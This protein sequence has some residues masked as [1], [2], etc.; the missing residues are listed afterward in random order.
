MPATIEKPF[1]R[2][3]KLERLAKQKS[4]ASEEQKRGNVRKTASFDFGNSLLLYDGTPLPDGEWDIL[5]A[6]LETT[7]ELNVTGA[8][9][10]ELVCNDPEF[11][12]LNDSWFEKWMLEP[13]PASSEKT[14]SKT[15]EV[16][17]DVESILGEE[18][19]EA[20][21][22][23]P[24]KH[25][26]LRLDGTWFRLAGFKVNEDKLTLLWEDLLA[27]ILRA[28]VGSVFTKTRS[29]SMTRAKFAHEL[30][31]AAVSNPKN[32][33][34]G[35]C[36]FWCPEEGIKQQVE[37]EAEEETPGKGGEGEAASEEAGSQE[38][39][40]TTTDGITVKGVAATTSQLKVINEGLSA[41]GKLSAPFKAKVALVEALI[42]ENG[43]SN[44]DP[45]NEADMGCL[46]V[47]ASTARGLGIN[48][49][50]IVAVCEHFLA[51][52]FAG[53][54]GAI[55]IA[56]AEPNL[57]AGEIAQKVQGSGAGAASKGEA[58]YGKWKAEAEKAVNTFQGAKGGTTSSSANTAPFQFTR[59]KNQTSW[60]CIQALAQEVGWYAFVRGNTLFWVSGEYLY[61][62]P[63][64]MLVERGKGGVDWV[65]PVVELGARD[66]VAE[67]EVI[68][69]AGT[70]TALPGTCVRVA[71]IGPLN[72]KWLVNSITQDVRDPSEAIVVK[73]QK[74]LPAKK[75]KPG[76]KAS[77]TKGGLKTAEGAFDAA[78]KLS[79]MDLD[80]KLGGGH[81]PGA[82]AHISKESP[83]P[84]DCS[85]STSWIL[86]EAGMFPS[87]TAED[88]SELENWGDPGEGKEMTVW[89]NS[90][91][92]FIEFKIPGH[93]PA[94]A[95]TAYPNSNGPR[96]ITNPVFNT[97][98]K[99]EGFTPRHWPGT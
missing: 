13:Q 81:G 8:S 90:A 21:W 2:D 7:L 23:L 98:P 46:S 6:V 5:A 15:A 50:D 80:Y 39:A 17:E 93:E 40:L 4:L 26:D 9:T 66:S 60:D 74:P 52:G 58:T 85:S 43:C 95:N 1:A 18:D 45:G 22:V 19:Q 30:F 54:G 12:L 61:D 92:V 38:N 16:K 87:T 71:R 96:L 3:P 88:S 97:N 72:G 31:Q 75:E 82:L 35:D 24:E 37:A 79:E 59:G 53:A 14:T 76:S 86:H 29:G 57:S 10:F 77:T 55:A 49:Y 20:R 25:I 51:A 94:Q 89:A 32:K 41:C 69:R 84:L 33:V 36:A 28:E 63:T 64:Q 48:V 83:E 42:T 27:A 62:Q 11:S 91:H 73:L 68:A 47:I 78:S 70:W 65:N 44:P 34:R 67:V 56:K 99:A